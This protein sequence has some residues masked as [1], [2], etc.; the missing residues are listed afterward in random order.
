M[1]FKPASKF[2]KF[3]VA[4]AAIVLSA[5]AMAQAPAQQ[6]RSAADPKIEERARLIGKELRC[7]VC[8]NQSIDESNSP[9]ALDL[10]Q[11][12]RERLQ[13]GDTDEQAKAFLV[14]R[15]G[16][17]VLL[18]F[19]RANAKRSAAS[20]RSTTHRH[21]RTRQGGSKQPSTAP[22][23]S[24]PNLRPTWSELPVWPGNSV[25]CHRTSR[26]AHRLQMAH[27]VADFS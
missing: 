2:T 22:S 27:P 1:A 13:A 24:S 15:Y 7:V 26:R 9:L 23:R 16:N 11:L 8:Q 3:G 18:K 17:F 19:R 12:L 4:A 25:W 20:P 14:A 10:K 21:P 6:L 5:A